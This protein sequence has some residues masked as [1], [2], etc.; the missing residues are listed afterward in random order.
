MDKRFDELQN[1]LIDALEAAHQGV[2]DQSLVTDE[3][4]YSPVWW[5]MRGYEPDAA[6]DNSLEGWLLRVHPDDCTQVLK[7]V[8]QQNFLRDVNC[9]FEYRERHAQGH[10]IWIQSRG[11]A[12]AWDASGK[13]TRVLGTDTDI[14]RQKQLEMDVITERQRLR[15]M[16]SSIADAVIATDIAGLITYMNPSATSLALRVEEDCLGKP[17]DKV[18]TLFGEDMAPVFPVQECQFSQAKW[19]N[20][21]LTLRVYRSIS[22]NVRCV[23]SALE[24][25]HGK[26]E[27]YV[28][29]LEDVSLSRQLERRLAFLANHDTLTRLPNR[30]A[31]EATVEKAL[32]DA[33]DKDVTYSLCCVDLDRFKQIN[34]S[35]GHAAGDYAL[36]QVVVVMN[37]W[38]QVSDYIARVGGDEFIILMRNTTAHVAEQRMAA[39]E[40]AVENMNGIFEGQ[41]FELGLSFGVAQIRGSS[42][43]ADQVLRLADSR[44]YAHKS[45]VRHGRRE[46]VSD[47]G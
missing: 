36:Q 3:T 30:H 8:E 33:R 32:T 46:R 14:T 47:V 23:V 34:D 4:Y 15:V 22:K 16:L 11:R 20:K 29:V 40:L 9:V 35:L 42:V 37:Q 6:L 12:V 44:C 24:Q 38:K 5:R 21:N 19:E 43:D 45:R 1:R 41:P 18:F 31:F 28:V 39:L 25:S 10:Y 7:T 26:T 2:W 27:G 17:I 13:A